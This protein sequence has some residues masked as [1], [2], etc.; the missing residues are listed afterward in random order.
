MQQKYKF[1]F[2]N[3]NYVSLLYLFS[4]CHYRAILFQVLDF[5]FKKINIYYIDELD[6]TRFRIA[7]N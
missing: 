4:L 7:L 1:I 2:T 3:S 5:F 6:I